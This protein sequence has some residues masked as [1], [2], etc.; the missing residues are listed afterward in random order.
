M[1]EQL[2]GYC[3]TRKKTHPGDHILAFNYIITGCADVGGVLSNAS[4]EI[5]TIHGS[6]VARGFAGEGANEGVCKRY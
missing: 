1:T 5:S 6:P 2:S 4:P 3:I